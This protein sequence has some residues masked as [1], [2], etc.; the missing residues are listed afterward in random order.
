MKLEKVIRALTIMGLAGVLASN[1][2]GAVK[3][4]P[5]PQVQEKVAKAIKEAFPDAVI[6]EMAKE[7]EDGLEVI[8]VLFT[9]Q[10]NKID[11]DVTPDGILLETEQS[12]DI[13]AFP[14][15]A[16]KALKKATKKMK[17]TFEIARTFAKAQKDASGAMRVAKLAE[18]TIAYE[19]DVEQD[20]HKGEFA[21]DASGKLLESPKWA[22]GSSK[23][24]GESGK[25]EKEEN[26]EK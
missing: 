24:R 3:E 25:E 8:G 7:T 23:S 4:K 14:R 17:A 15:P 1:A 5:A 19:A 6:S 16:A 26:E 9:S 12:A 20:G 21:F 13:S 11:A 2:S 22:K 10:G 18:P